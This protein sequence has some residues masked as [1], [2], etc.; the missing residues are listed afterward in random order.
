MKGEPHFWAEIILNHMYIIT[1]ID[2]LRRLPLVVTLTKL[3]FPSTFA[4]RNRNSEY[5]RQKVSEYVSL[6]ISAGGY[7]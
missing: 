6:A 2:N 7:H 4:L 5:S 1:L 3:L